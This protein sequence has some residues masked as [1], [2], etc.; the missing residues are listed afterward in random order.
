MPEG[1]L[2]L[3][4]IKRGTITAPAGCGKTQLIAEAL[5]RHTH[6][7]PI[8]VLT[9][10]NAGVAALR[11]RL[12]RLGVRRFAYRLST[13]DG[14]A[15]RLI[16]TFPK[17]SGHDPAI[18]SLQ[19]PRDDYQAI[20]GAAYRLLKAGHVQDALA[21]TYSRLVVDEHQDCSLV[22]HAVVYFA[23]TALPTVVLGDPLQA[24]FDFA[25]TLAGWE[26]HVCKHF[27]PAGELTIPWRWK[28]AGEEGFGL[29]LLDV[30][31]KLLA[32]EAIDLRTA[33][34][35]V[36]WIALNGH[37]DHEKLLRACRVRPPN[38]E[39]T[40]LIIGDSRN[41]AGQR[42]FA[43]QTPDAVT[44]ENVDLRDLVSFAAALDL[45]ASSAL[46]SVV[47]FAESVMTNVGGS[48]VLRRVDSLRRGTARNPAN[49]VEQA[50]LGFLARPSH[51]GVRNLL[52]EIGRQ[53]GVRNH[54]PGILR[55]CI[56]ALQLAEMPDGPSFKEAAIRVREQSRALGR[57]LPRRAV[58]STL[59]LKGLE[60]DVSVI[61]NGS[62]QSRRNLYVAMTRGSRRLVVCAPDAV[63]N[64]E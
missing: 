57:P 18:L 4:A 39:G 16:S 55:G 49:D 28:N 23:A 35:N 51:A 47:G 34:P 2:D 53:T 19:R 14:W 32:G 21:A 50:A 8:L 54:R 26:E 25:G 3:L 5:T 43:S 10:T 30:R 58:G 31:K 11:T 64:P 15:M 59:L 1:N 63:L 61:L 17:R 13:I 44:I 48:D 40:V 36:S 60:A 33:P 9:H 29:W 22:Q 7:K 42:Q 46:E 56:R 6:Q 20:R 45:S 52:G 27:P 12:E 37:E 38:E 24:I 62:D 41:P